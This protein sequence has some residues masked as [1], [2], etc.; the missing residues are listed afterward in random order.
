MIM[1]THRS[2]RQQRSAEK[3]ASAK[4]NCEQ[5][6]RQCE[7]AA[8]LVKSASD[9]LAECWTTL[10]REISTGVSARELLRR[11][12]WC[13]VLELRLKERAHALEEA[14]H[15]IDAV[16]KEMMQSAQGREM[17]SDK[18]ASLFTESWSLLMQ[19]PVTPLP[20]RTSTR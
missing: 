6:L 12:A 8:A 13:N 7:E 18:D 10:G 5:A 4:P 14:R 16:W 3:P 11:R 20:T 19:P 17:L 1:K 9:E 15:S 2:I